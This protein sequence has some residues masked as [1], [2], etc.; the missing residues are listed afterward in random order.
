MNKLFI[1]TF[2][3]IIGIFNSAN[4][5]TP[6]WEQTTVCRISTNKCYSSSM[7][8][9]IDRNIW[10]SDSNC[11]GQKII[12][13]DALGKNEKNTPM[14]KTEISKVNKDF[15]TSKLSSNNEC[16]GQR[17]TKSNGTQALINGNY[18]KVW[19]K[20]ILDNQDEKLSNGYITSGPQPTCQDLADKHFIA[21][22]NNT[23]KCLAV[24]FCMS[25]LT[26]CIFSPFLTILR[27]KCQR[28]CK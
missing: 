1:Y 11:W 15:D 22:I 19:C 7:K 25:F 10:D 14:S 4:A 26:A 6:W 9:G 5:F 18:V 20:D 28:E 21:V 17:Y 8:D 27:R 2:L 12:C 16:Y 23:N 24:A 13:A 3:S